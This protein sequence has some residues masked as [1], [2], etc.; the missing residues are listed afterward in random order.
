MRFPYSKPSLIEADIH[1]VLEVL[2]GQF[3][4]QGHVVEA[5]ERELEKLF[6]VQHAVVCNSGTA[7][8]QMAYASLGLGPR[9]GLITSPI[10]FVATANAAR[11]CD[12]PVSFAD[13]D[14]KT[15]NVTI[16]SI[17]KAVENADFPVAAVSVV[18]LAGLPCEID[19]IGLYCRNKNISVIEDAC[20]APWAMYGSKRKK[21]FHV[22][23]C[24]HSQATTLSFHA[25]KHIA[26]GEGGVLLTN[27][28]QIRDNALK[29]RSHGIEYSSDKFLDTT[30][31][32]NP[33]YYEMQ[34]LG[35]N[36]RLNEMSCAL[37]LSQLAR[38]PSNIG[39]RDAIADVYSEH[40]RD[41]ETVS[42]P[43]K[44][45]DNILSHAWHLYPIGVNYTDIGLSRSQLML[46]LR[47]LGVGTQVHYIPIYRHPY[48]YSSSNENKFP[49]AEAYYGKTLSLP[50]YEDLQKQDVVEIC[51]RLREC[52]KGI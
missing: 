20:H 44:P 43:K 49:G 42:T 29:L 11:L 22:G 23:S 31:R 7:A 37:A 46:K 16:Q 45:I 2:K 41:I 50:M 12:A 10:S 26:A 36:F 51:E 33:W 32:D 8:L 1:A 48:Y 34:E 19:E 38:L 47:N 39:H 21:L 18:H 9:A 6:C 40:L 35:Y 14:P 24:S 3:L 28:Q 13:V 5:L 15:G 30:N 4:T 52:L 27:D 17:M 25:I